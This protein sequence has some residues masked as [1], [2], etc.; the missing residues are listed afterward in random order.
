[1][2]NLKK[3]KVVTVWLL[4]YIA[5]I[6]LPLAVSL[7][8][9]SV[10]FDSLKKQNSSL[11]DF[12]VDYT[13][14]HIKDV[15]SDIQNLY[16]D[17]TTHEDLLSA[18]SVS[19]H[20]EYFKKEEV[21]S[22]LNYFARTQLFDDEYSG[23]FLYVPETEYVLSDKGIVDSRTYF[24]VYHGG[25]EDDFN[26][27]KETLSV[28]EK[29]FFFDEMKCKKETKVIACMSKMPWNIRVHGH[30]AVFC[31][32]VSKDEFFKKSDKAE[33]MATAQTY[34]YDNNDRLLFDNEDESHRNL[35]LNELIDTLLGDQV[36][37]SNHISLDTTEFNVVM[38]V[39]ESRLF[40]QVVS[41]RNLFVISTVIC[42]IASLVLVIVLVN[43]NYRPL[44]EIM[45]EIGNAKAADEFAE[46]KRF[47]KSGILN[48]VKEQTAMRQMILSH[49]LQ[50]TYRRYYTPEDLTNYGIE[51]FRQNY[52]IMVLYAGDPEKYAYSSNDSLYKRFGELQLIIT[53]VFEELFNNEESLAY[54]INI[55]D[56]F[57]CVINTQIS[58]ETESFK[59][60]AE[61]GIE[62]LN[63]EFELDIKYAVS[64]IHNDMD[65]LFKA[66]EEANNSLKLQN[67]QNNEV[68]ENVFTKA[69]AQNGKTDEDVDFKKHISASAGLEEAILDYI[70]YNYQNTEL[71]VDYLSRHFN[72]SSSYLSLQFKKFYGESLV[73]FIHKFRILE[74][75]E[76]L[77]KT[78]NTVAYIAKAVGYTNIRTFNRVFKKYEGITPTQ[79]QEQNYDGNA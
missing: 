43:L 37:V 31:A 44:R 1:M 42:I 29:G 9:Y 24:E 56:L 5:V 46:I 52:I 71:N 19:E 33:W 10:F 59:R 36:I 69:K 73:D 75:K 34:I 53:N 57:Y 72:K 20:D 18:L 2:Y 64:R 48:N 4:S 62:V 39:S 77:K 32:I 41:M 49:L 16:M 8:N 74:A 23:F 11:T 76:Q 47:I 38:V 28:S 40:E 63:K 45:G 15:I 67:I 30:E 51:F 78:D 61:N 55:G 21:Q 58:G 14:S 54:V 13:T 50:G 22:L 3:S 35:S 66:Y 17:V 68:L 65:E 7:F 12:A 79:Y 6:L 25:T 70:Y 26:K 60:L 27:W